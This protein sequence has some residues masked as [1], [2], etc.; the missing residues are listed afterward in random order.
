[1]PWLPIA[2]GLLLL[3]GGLGCAGQVSSDQTNS[4]AAPLVVLG[5]AE[6]EY[7]RGV[8]RAFELE[9]GIQTS[10]VR[11]SS[12]E[13]LTTLNEERATPRF[14]V[15]WGGPVD[16]YI[17]AAADNLLEQYQPRGSA[18]IPRQYKD[19]N[20]YWTGIYVGALAIAVNQ[21]VL[22]E[23]G[24]PEPTSWADLTNP[25]YKGQISMAHPA[26]SGTAYTTIATIVQINGKDTTKGFAYIE[27]LHRNISRYE[28]AGA[29]PARVAGRGEAAVAIAFSHDILGAIEDGFSTLKVLFPSDGTGY[30]IG[31]MA[32][33]NNAPNP[34]AGKRFMDWALSERAQELGPLF[35]AYQIPTN[36]DA[37][38]PP[39]SLRLS[40]VKTIDYDF[41]WAGE[42][43]Q[44]LVERFSTVIAPPPS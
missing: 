24:L 43:R 44:A 35:T 27:A 13:A 3:M 12:G 37:K 22:S 15:L 21:Q 16:G 11:Q 5:S 25:I 26:T 9:T 39:Q 28:R 19:Q 8:V 18:K 32:L 4:G 38:I 20:G 2:L 42:N 17:A 6:E 29:A 30:E 31:A 36:P 41:R 34:V 40:S 10:Y 14:S 33:L 7:V 23:R 1:M